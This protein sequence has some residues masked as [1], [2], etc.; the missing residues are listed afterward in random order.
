MAPEELGGLLSNCP[1][2]ISLNLVRGLFVQAG[3]KTIRSGHSWKAMNM[4]RLLCR[5]S[6]TL[7]QMCIFLKVR[8]KLE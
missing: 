8:E 4:T 1:Y 5:N 3:C 6:F 7:N 2:V